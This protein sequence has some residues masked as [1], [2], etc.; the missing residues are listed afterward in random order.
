M[1]TKINASTAGVGGLESIADNSGVLELQTGGTTKVTIDGSGNVGINTS[2]PANKFEVF[3]NNLR[4]VVRASSTAGDV[5]IEAQAS[6]YWSGP[7]YRGTHLRQY[8]HTA[9]GTN[10]GLPN[11]GL[12][13]LSFQNTSAGL[14]FTNGAV[15]LVFGTTAAERLRIDS[16]GAIGIGGANYGTAG[17]VLTSGGSGAAPS[18]ETGQQ[19]G[20]GQTWQNV[21]GSRA[22]N[23]TY[24]NSLSKPIQIHVIFAQTGQ[25]QS[26]T[27]TAVINGVSFNTNTVS[28]NNAIVNIPITFS[29]I[30]PAGHTYRINATGSYALRDWAELR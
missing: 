13:I 12:G 24:T 5:L 17:Q 27:F 6:D 15:P 23:T 19:I 29:L 11:A 20:V 16:T 26:A 9:T 25:N 2:T 21:T 1:A 30:I 4:N 8:G 22:A 18:W 14:I 7:S 3:G 28:C 10:V